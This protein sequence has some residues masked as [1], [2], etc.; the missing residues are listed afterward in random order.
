MAKSNKHVLI[1]FLKLF[2]INYYFFK[3]TKIGFHKVPVGYMKPILELFGAELQH[4]D[5]KGCHR[6][7]LADLALCH[8]LQDLRI[9][10][11]KLHPPLTFIPQQIDDSTVEAATFL[12]QLKSLESN[13][14][15]GHH[16][17]L[18]EEKS[19]LVRLVLNCSHVDIKP[20]PLRKRFKAS[21]EVSLCLSILTLLYIVKFKFTTMT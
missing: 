17:R 11:S 9:I 12:P 8:Q 2:K 5:F 16:S 10:S 14:C 18:F 4:L 13:V 6:I 19:T 3:L 15:L 1:K 7:K 21:A 20:E